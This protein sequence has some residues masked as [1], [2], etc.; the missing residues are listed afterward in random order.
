[1]VSSPRLCAL[2]TRGPGRASQ[3][4]LSARFCPKGHSC[5]QLIKP[6]DLVLGTSS[7]IG[8]RT[9]IAPH[10]PRS[11]TRDLACAVGGP[12]PLHDVSVPI[13]SATFRVGRSTLTPAGQPVQPVA[14]PQ[15][16]VFSARIPP[17]LPRRLAAAKFA[18]PFQPGRFAAYIP[19]LWW[20]MSS[21]SRTSMC[22][23]TTGGGT[24]P[25]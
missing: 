18:E 7:W 10:V 22:S 16:T 25:E 12:P 21:A 13:K 6:P 23:S 14:W 2:C 4:N 24:F 17:F 9:C 15:S 19:A 11:I 8:N 5:P 20:H 3:F 1:M